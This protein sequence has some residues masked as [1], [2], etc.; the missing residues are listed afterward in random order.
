MEF[1]HIALI[2][3]TGLVAGFVN[4]VG[5]GGSLLTLPMLIFLGLPS[6]TANGTNRVAVL[7][8]SAV[9]V[10]GFRHKGIFDLHLG[11]LLGLPGLFGSILGARLAVDLPDAIFN[12]VLAAVMLL[13]LVIILFEPHKRFITISQEF[14]DNRRKIIAAVVFFFI[15]IYGGFIQAGVGFIIIACLSI[16]AGMS[17]VKINSLKVFVTTTFMLSSLAVFVYSGNIDWF[18]AFILAV[19]NALG[20]WFGSLFAV[21]KGDKWIKAI[22]VVSVLAMAAKLLGIF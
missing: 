1:S 21:A 7:V 16:I 20:G 10:A 8:Q 12:N 5:G 2:A 14:L 11:L 18:I 17:L 22:L 4:T 6:A 15:G 13:V 19:G 9:A 3:V